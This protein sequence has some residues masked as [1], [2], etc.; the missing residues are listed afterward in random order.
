M[1]DKRDKGFTVAQSPCLFKYRPCIQSLISSFYG[2]EVLLSRM[3]GFREQLKQQVCL[4]S[5]S[6]LVWLLRTFW[7]VLRKPIKAEKALR[8][9]SI[10][11]NIAVKLITFRRAAGA[12]CVPIAAH[13]R[14]LMLF[15][16]LLENP[17]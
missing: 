14:C 10:A 16:S 15:C 8:T 12:S 11:P 4:G 2:A 6:A 5:C 3:E 9:K 17:G 13:L 7:H 1:E